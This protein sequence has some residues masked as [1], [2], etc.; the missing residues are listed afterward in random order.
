[1]ALKMIVQSV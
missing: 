1:M